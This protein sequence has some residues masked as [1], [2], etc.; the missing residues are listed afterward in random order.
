MREP[1]QSATCCAYELCKR[2]DPIEVIPGHRRKQ[3]HDEACR[4]AQH[5]RLSARK[6]YAALCQ[7]WAAFLPETQQALQQLLEEHGEIWTRRIIAAITDELDQAG[8]PSLSEDEQAA[9]RELWADLQPFTRNIL[10]SLVT[11]RHGLLALLNLITLA[12][13][14][15]RTHAICNSGLEQRAAYLEIMLAEYRRI[16]D[17]SDEEKIRQQFMAVGQLLDY[18]ALP[19]YQVGAGLDKWEDYRSWTDERTLAEVVIYARV[20]LAQESAVKE[21]TTRKSKLRHAEKQL[22]NAQAQVQAL[23]EQVEALEAERAAWTA[24]KEAEIVFSTQ[25]TA[26]RRYLQEHA[27]A[28]IPI[29]RNG[30]MLKVVALGNDSLAVT[31]DHGLVRLSDDEL[32]QGRLWVAQKTGVP[33]IAIRQPIGAKT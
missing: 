12:I 29:V 19:K 17:L 1:Y 8:Q 30:V 25:L 14:E 2:A 7:L 15:E 9:F 6:T 3:Y 33:V 24:W 28:A 21:D 10:E 4:Q 13:G 18:R 22:T 5:R 20:V 26:M 16:I 23:Q 11:Q 31:E 27:E 32:E